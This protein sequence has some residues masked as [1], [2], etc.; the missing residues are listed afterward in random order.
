EIE[1]MNIL[2]L[3]ADTTVQATEWLAGSG[4]L[5][6][7]LLIVALIVVMIV[8]LST[9]LVVQKAIK[10]IIKLTM[11]EVVAEEAAKKSKKIDWN[12]LWSK[13]LSL[14]PLEEEKDLEIDH[15]YDGIKELNNPV[16]GW[17]N[18]LFY[19]T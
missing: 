17:F 15:A 18:A 2:L 11:P 9:A 12:A 3:S 13:L 4:N 7:D 14:R 16:P 8:L 10:S 6:S 1:I 19:G 5:Y